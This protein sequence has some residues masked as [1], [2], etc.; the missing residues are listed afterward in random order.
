MHVADGCAVVFEGR[1]PLRIVEIL[2]FYI[3]EV[4]EGQK[5]DQY[6]RGGYFVVCQEDKPVFVRDDVGCPDPMLRYAY[7]AKSH[8]GITQGPL[9]LAYPPTYSPFGVE[10]AL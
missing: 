9:Q 8:F 3:I 2:Y 5:R 6:A 10:V 1:A 7:V 4:K